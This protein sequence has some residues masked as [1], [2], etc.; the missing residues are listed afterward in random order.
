MKVII[1]VL[2]AFPLIN[3][4]DIIAIKSNPIYI[5]WILEMFFFKINLISH[6]LCLIIVF[7]FPH[8]YFLPLF[9]PD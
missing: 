8:Q 6:F 1:H 2:K 9:N 3:H 5:F 7:I 4:V